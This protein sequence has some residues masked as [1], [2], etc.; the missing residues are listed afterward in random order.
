ESWE[1]E[2]K[3][4]LVEGGEVKTPSTDAFMDEVR[5]QGVEMFAQKCNSKS[6]QSLTSDI[7]D[8]WKL[9]GEHATYFAAQI[10]KG[11]NQ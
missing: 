10:R 5:A 7:R 2:C 1:H 11:G 4:E 3:I 9:L 6:E 8:N